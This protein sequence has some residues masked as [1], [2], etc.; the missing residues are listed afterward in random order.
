MVN[1]QKDS[2]IKTLVQSIKDGGIN[3]FIEKATYL[4]ATDVRC[5]LIIR[6]FIIA[7]IVPPIL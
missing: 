6:I 2:L 1:S 4:Y 3:S 7:P 5:R